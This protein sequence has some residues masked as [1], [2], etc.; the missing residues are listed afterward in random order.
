MH[1]RQRRFGQR[2]AQ[3]EVE[4]ADLRRQQQALVDHGAGRERRHVELAE[5]RQVLLV[6][7]RSRSVVQDLL[8]DRQDLALERVLVLDPRAG[9]DDRLA[10]HRHRFDARVL[11]RPVRS[12]GT[13][14]QPISVWPSAATNRSNWWMA[15]SRAASSLRQEAHGDGVAPGRRQLQRPPCPPSRAAGV[16]HL[17]QAAGAVAHQRV[18]ADRAAMVEVDQDLQAATDDLVR[19]AALDVGHEADA[20]RIVLVA[21]IIQSLARRKAHRR[22]LFTCRRRRNCPAGSL[23]VLV[24][25][26]KPGR[27]RYPVRPSHRRKKLSAGPLL[28]NKTVTCSTCWRLPPCDGRR[29]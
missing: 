14:R 25:H 29:I 24:G 23:S 12:V 17:D 6:L 21:W 3:V 15:N 9:G 20:A 8:A 13:S 19:L 10:D 16:G 11:P 18:G 22:S 28:C 1:Q 27:T 5:A 2:V 4:A 7:D 26:A